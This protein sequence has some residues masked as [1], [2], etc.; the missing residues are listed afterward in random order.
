MHLK[1]FILNFMLG[2]ALVSLVT[3]L[4]SQGKGML[5]AFI[6]T[7][8]TMTVITFAL[9]YNTAGRNAT[10]D[11]A[12]G[13]LLMTPPWIIYVLCLI[14]LL[15]R[16]GFVKSLV[17]GVITYMILAGCVSIVTKHFSQ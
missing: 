15:P 14:F 8:P 9:I 6:A 1:N 12:R 2:G 16:L 17:I 7:F 5:A 11:Y 3:F 4:G 10:V 13:L